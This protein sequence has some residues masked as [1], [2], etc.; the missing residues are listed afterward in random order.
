MKLVF[1]FTK[2]HV[3]V[4]LI[5]ILKIV[6]VVRTLGV[7]TFPDDKVLSG[8]DANKG[9]PAEGALKLE[10]EICPV[11]VWIEAPAADLAKKLTATTVIT[12]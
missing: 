1:V 2:G 7:N 10:G 12:V 9:L 3:K 11:I 5:D 4:F 8:F 6:K